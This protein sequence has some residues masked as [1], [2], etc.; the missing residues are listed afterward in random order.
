MSSERPTRRRFLAAGTGLVAAGLSGC[1][2]LF[3]GD[4]PSPSEV[5]DRDVRSIEVGETVESDLEQSDGNDPEWNDVA[6]P[7]EFD[8]EENDVVEVTMTS[9]VFDPYLVLEAPDGDVVAMNNDANASRPES[10][11]SGASWIWRRLP[12]SGTYTIWAGS[13]AGDGIGAYS[14][15]LAAN[16]EAS[17]EP[18][19]PTIEYGQVQNRQIT[20]DSGWDPRF[21]YLSDPVAFQGS[22]G[23]A[24]TITMEAEDV[25]PFLVLEAPNG[26]ILA[27]NDDG[28]GGGD[29]EIQQTLRADGRY[30]IWAGTRDGAATTSYTLSLLGN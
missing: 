19:Y 7:V 28:A 10:D 24:V 11:D 13:L 3:E 5:G 8:G 29:S 4:G 6:E 14:L 15:S 17:G 27:T 26:A 1:S 20:D 16:A 9:E 2:A 22:S 23:D 21:T 18:D 12:Q 30:V 25:D